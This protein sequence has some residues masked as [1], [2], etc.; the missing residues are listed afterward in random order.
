VSNEPTASIV[1]PTR[2]R[3]GY[4]EITL[5][6]VAPQAEAAGAEVIVVDDGGDAETRD[7]SR[8]HGARLISLP[9]PGGANA[10]RN[11]G[12]DAARSELI[13]LIDDDIEAAAGWLQAILAGAAGAPHA[14]VFGGPIR[15][16]LEG[17]G[18]RACGREPAPIT[19]LDLGPADRDVTLV[20]SANM[21]IRRRGLQLAGRFDATLAGRGE[22]EDWE[23]RYIAQ[24]GVVRYLAGAGVEHRRTA[25]DC[26]LS[27]L[28]RSAYGHGRAGRRYDVRKGSAPPLPAELRTLV[29]CI[30]HV[31]RRRCLIGIVMAAQ[32]AGRLREALA[33]PS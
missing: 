13:V 32:A 4:L 29:G 12:I 24:G 18:P 9:P 20:W 5:A 23:R 10:G 17:G 11:A 21:A 28:A 7:V 15:A 19:T 25:P 8:R 14:D 27:H 33:R 16:R 30:W 3:P 22:E 2:G 31:F 6:S 26:T 1:I